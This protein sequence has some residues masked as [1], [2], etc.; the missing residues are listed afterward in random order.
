MTGAPPIAL[1]MVLCDG[2]HRDRGS[3]KVYVLGTFS[4]IFA[5]TFPAMHPHFVV[6]IQLTDGHQNCDLTLK[7]A[8]LKPDELDGT[9]LQ[10]ATLPVMFADR[11]AVVELAIGFANVVLPEAGEYRVILEVGGILIMERRLLALPTG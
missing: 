4:T 7:L 8:Q 1:A 2:V 11:R 10:E 5:S 3:G 9:P 6:Y